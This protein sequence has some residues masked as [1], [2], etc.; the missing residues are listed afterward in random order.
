[1]RH[2][3][4]PEQDTVRLNEKIRVP[5]VRL[6]DETGTLVGVVATDDAL[7]RAQRLGLDLVEVAADSRPPVCKILDYGK[8]RF[9]ERKKKAQARKNQKT[10]DVKELQFT[11]KIEE[12]DYQVKHRN[13]ERFLKAGHKVRIVL[14]FKGREM[15]HQDVG[16]ERMARIVGDLEAFGKVEFAPKMEGRRMLAV[17]APLP[18][19]KD[20]GGQK[21]SSP[22]EAK[23]EDPKQDVASAVVYTPST[24][25][26]ADGKTEAS[27]AS[28]V[29]TTVQDT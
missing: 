21:S 13:G 22:R 8:L 29:S 16:A 4:N 3:K 23:A 12:H 26:E 14:R 1:M 28:E 11:L 10:L 15:G 18:A 5:Q 24:S 7:A 27:S 6:V 2:V 17:L 19:T 20:K 25:S 9:E